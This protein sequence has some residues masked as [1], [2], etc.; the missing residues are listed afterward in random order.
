MGLARNT[1]VDLKNGLP[2]R[3]LADRLHPRGVVFIHVP[4]CAG[5]S[6]ENALRA[7]FRLS[8]FMIDPETSFSATRLYGKSGQHEKLMQA[9]ELR[10]HML[11]YA[12]ASG[13]KCITGHA[14]LGIS[15]IPEATASHDFI[16]VL[17]DPVE[18]F[19]SHL[20]FNQ[21]DK[22]GH[23][24]ITLPVTE[25]LTSPRAHVMGNLYGKYFSGLP[26]QADLGGRE[27]VDRSKQQLTLFSAVGFLDRLDQFNMKVSALT[28]KK[29][30]PGHDNRTIPTPHEGSDDLSGFHDQI[31]DLCQTDIEIYN[32]A[33]QEFST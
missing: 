18:R 6:I 22:S 11:H 24:R 2:P 12:L 17:R 21:T 28:G 25:F 7:Q 26:M 20:R 3:Q 15:T 32:W 29:L 14:P 23:G 10:R 4:K 31:E 16:T 5:T 8:R 30:Q 19:Y 1:L 9:S 13:Y 33:R 27:A